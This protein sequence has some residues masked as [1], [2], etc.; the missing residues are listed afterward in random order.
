MTVAQFVQQ[1]IDQAA[2]DLEAARANRQIGFYDTSI[3]LC[4]QSAEKYLKAL[5]ARQQ[6]A[7]PPRMHDLEQLARTVSAPANVITASATLA[8]EYLIARYPD[9]AQTTPY[10]RYT[11]ADADRHLA[12]AEEVQQWVLTQLP[13]STP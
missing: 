6:A 10:T 7:T 11:E 3:V 9:V 5:W 1:W 2:H 12:L 8:D 13:S 4:Q